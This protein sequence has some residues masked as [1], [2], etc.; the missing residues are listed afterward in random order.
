[1]QS[2]QEVKLFV[3]NLPYFCTELTLFEAF[4]RFG[5][6]IKIRIFRR[7]KSEPPQYAF[8]YM[9]MKDAAIAKMNLTSTILQGRKIIVNWENRPNSTNLHGR[10][11]STSVSIHFKFETVSSSCK[12]QV[13][14]VIVHE[15]FVRQYFENFGRIDDVI[16]KKSAYNDDV[17]KY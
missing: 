15:D 7:T 2:T 9:P 17:R 4:K 12:L 11:I 16:L 5:K 14:D 1:M 10:P 6:V 13:Q 8:I 3:G